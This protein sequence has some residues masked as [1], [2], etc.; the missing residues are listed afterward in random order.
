M[1]VIFTPSPPTVKTIYISIACAEGGRPPSLLQ[2]FLNYAQSRATIGVCDFL[3]KNPKFA[4]ATLLTPAYHSLIGC[5][6]EPSLI[7]AQ[8]AKTERPIFKPS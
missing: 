1:L 3:I 6:V 8:G 5:G 2:L 7:A 4:I